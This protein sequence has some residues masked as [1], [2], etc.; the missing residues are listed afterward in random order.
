[1]LSHS[2]S[3]IHGPVPLVAALLLLGDD[4]L[5]SPH[6]IATLMLVRHSPEQIDMN[7]T[8]LHTLLERRLLALEPR[9][10]GHR[11]LSLTKTGSQLLEAVGRLDPI[12]PEANGAT[13][14]G[15]LAANL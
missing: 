15:R 8:E 7:R 14:F 1:M 3:T 5:L 12:F 11:R 13:G 2:V 6:E 4:V 10:E 9:T